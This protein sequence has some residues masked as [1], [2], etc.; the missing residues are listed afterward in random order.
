M[1]KR[2]TTDIFIERSNIIHDN[3]YSYPNTKYINND[4]YVKI[5]C[6]KHGEFIQNSKSHMDGHGCSECG[7]NHFTTIDYI[8]KVNII[9]KF[10]Y[11]Y[12]K[13]I[14]INYSSDIIIY[15]D[16]HGYFSQNAKLHLNGNGCPKCANNV[17]TKIEIIEKVYLLHNN[18]Y[19]Y[20]DFDFCYRMSETFLNI[21]C[22]KHGHFKQRLN[23]HIHQLN[24]CPNC[25]ESKGENY[26]NELLN[27][28]NIKYKRQ[29]KFDGCK[30][31]RLLPFDFYLTEYNICI[32]FDGIQHFEPIY[33]VDVLNS[34]KNN[35]NIKNK[36]CLNNN[37]VLLRIKY[38]EDIIEKLNFLIKI[39]N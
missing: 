12:D 37:I 3:F 24:G 2:L 33:G 11:K 17:Y 36:Y 10:K 28:N 6:T 39:N 15:C 19:I 1:G 27:K 20:D 5:V 14:F 4:C 31:K 8:E 21:Y 26:I 9:H 23:N 25:R 32:E 16:R 30:N 7:N 13:T 22:P 35:D 34:L 29:M 18:K 38:N